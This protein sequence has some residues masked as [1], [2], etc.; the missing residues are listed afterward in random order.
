[1]L[2]ELGKPNYGP[3]P[4]KSPEAEIKS[5]IHTIQIAVERLCVDKGEYPPYLLGGDKEGWDYYNANRPDG[6]PYL[7]DPLI[8]GGYTTS[9]PENPFYMIDNWK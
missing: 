8:E 5:N 4:D 3:G 2:Y 6:A 7:I 9:Y 1:M